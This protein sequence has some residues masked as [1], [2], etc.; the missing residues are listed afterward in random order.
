MELRRFGSRKMVL[1]ALVS[2]GAA[3]CGGS[4]RM[5][6]ASGRTEAAEGIV[7]AERGENDDTLVH[8]RLKYL[9]PPYRLAA[10]ASTYLVWV[11]APES[12]IQNAGVLTVDEDLAGALDFVTPH[13]TFR[14]T[15]TPESS[16]A[17][18]TP[19]N[20]PVFNATVD[21]R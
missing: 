3:G 17:R 2:V 13:R 16:P 5:R 8:V 15:V 11:E 18:T 6:P 4:E 10:D 12:P 19:Q 21:A 1:V 20:R 9:A 14:L 7:S